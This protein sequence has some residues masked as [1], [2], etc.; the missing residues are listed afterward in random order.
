MTLFEERAARNEALFREVNEQIALLA[1][2]RHAPPAQ[3]GF[4]CE[5]D[6]GDCTEHVFLT[7]DEYER[8]RRNSRRFFVLVG[9]ESPAIEVVVERHNGY[10]IVEK[11]GRAGLIAEKTDPHKAA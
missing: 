2:R 5:C 8:V 10:A 11:Q 7:P 9:H 6:N 1:D 4:M 3:V